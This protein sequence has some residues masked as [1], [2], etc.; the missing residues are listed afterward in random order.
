MVWEPV[1]GV[2]RVYTGCM[3]GAVRAVRVHGACY[4]GVDFYWNKEIY[5][6]SGDTCLMWT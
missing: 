5:F 4:M 2:Y 3:G 6:I 1:E